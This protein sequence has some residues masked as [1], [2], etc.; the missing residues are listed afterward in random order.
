MK[1]FIKTFGCRVNQTESQAIK[2]MF[3]VQGAQFVKNFEDAEIAVLNTC[4]VTSK[5]DSDVEKMTRQILARN[6]R[7]KLVLTGCYSAAHGDK[8]KKK[9]PKARIIDKYELARELFG[10][11]TCWTVS[12][13]EGRSRAFVKIQDGCDCFCSYCIV[14]FARNK[15]ISKPLADV[16]AEI[17]NL[18]SKNFR[19]IVLT[20]I[21]IGNYKCPATGADLA[22]L[23][24]EIFKLQGKFRIRFS[25]IELNTVTGNLIAAAKTGGGKFCNYFHIPLQSGS[26]KILK[27]MN[28]RYTAAEYAGRVSELRKIFPDIGIYADVIAGYPTETDGDFEETYN[29]IKK[30]KLSGLHVFS[31][32]PRPMTAA[33]KLPQLPPAAVKNRADKLRGLDKILRAD[34]A[35]SQAGKT[36]EVLAEKTKNGLTS[37]VSGNFLR[38]TFS[39]PA[40]AGSL[41]NIKITAAENDLLRGTVI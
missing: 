15:K 14:P 6:P 40:Q 13:A 41:L 2:E 22:G 12:G 3:A 23:A 16:T 1:V 21:N 37:G 26:D 17:Q 29:F 8:I 28:R 24:A 10:K 32:S 25:S 7:A 27:D 20:G 30:L 34:F 9:F 36:L 39:Q 5:A 11:D 38:V 18:I 4:T 33:E 35:A 19:E 31:F